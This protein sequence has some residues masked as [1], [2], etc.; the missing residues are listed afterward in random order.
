MG[1]T[2]PHGTKW[3][4]LSRSSQAPPSLK[5][6]LLASSPCPHH[7]PTMSPPCCAM[8]GHL[9]LSSPV[10][11]R[12]LDRSPGLFLGSIWSGR[13]PGELGYERK[14]GQCERGPLYLLKEF[15]PSS[16]GPAGKPRVFLKWYDKLF[17]LEIWRQGGRRTGR[18]DSRAKK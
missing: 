17:V 5:E 4:K 6:A 9:C 8:P 3:L 10:L 7:V 15:L 2:F 13:L 16:R 11:E 1:T 12:M 14:L 18:R